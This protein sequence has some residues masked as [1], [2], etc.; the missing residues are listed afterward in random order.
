MEAVYGRPFEWEELPTKRACRIAEYK[1]DC[2]V[3]ESERW[4]EYTDWFLNA[5]TRLRAALAAVALPT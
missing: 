3:A 5:G 1:A 2:S 4:D